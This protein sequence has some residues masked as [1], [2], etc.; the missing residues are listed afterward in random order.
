MASRSGF[1]LLELLVTCCLVA[2]VGLTA[3]ATL[4]GG[5]R[6]WERAQDQ[7]VF[8]QQVWL[9]LEEIRRD[10]HNAQPFHP[11]P[12]KGEYD[13]LSFP[14]FVEQLQEDGSTLREVGR[15]GFF[16]DENR[17]LL[18]RS[19]QP[20]RLLHNR[21]LRETGTPVAMGVERLRFHYYGPDLTTGG[22]SW[23]GSWSGEDPPLAVKIELGVR[24]ETKGKKGAYS[25]V[26]DLPTAPVAAP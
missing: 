5:L 9:A 23:V 3:A 2:L 10:L 26:I 20:Y 6:V 25:L 21:S 12:F 16:L 4:S 14:G 24:E 22:Y 1:S 18:C 11:I 13:V 19:K 17:H 8:D 7:G 15:I